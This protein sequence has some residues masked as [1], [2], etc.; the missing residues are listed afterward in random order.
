MAKIDIGS[1][2]K[3]KVPNEVKNLISNNPNDMVDTSNNYEE[4]KDKNKDLDL[5]TLQKIQN[6]GFSERAPVYKTKTKETI[7]S[8]KDLKSHLKNNNN[9]DENIKKEF[10]KNTLTSSTFFYKENFCISKLKKI[11]YKKYISIIFLIF[12]TILFIFSVLDLM[13]QVRNQKGTFLLCNLLLF[14]FEMMCSGIIILFHTIYYFINISHTNYIIFLIMSILI[15]V[16]SLIYIHTYIKKTVKFIEIISYMINNLLL[17]LI[18]IIYLCMSYN[19]IKKK[20]KMQQNIEDIMNY[21]LRNEKIG[22]NA[23]KEK[24]NKKNVVQ[25]VE[26]EAHY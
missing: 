15:I 8:N 26:E 13:K 12:S 16:F 2:Q 25:L 24:E 5:K 14:I 19:L 17:I 1:S 23:Q 22:N 9:K 10:K 11:Y 20:N 3:I 21:S 6:F 4:Q 7:I 18:N